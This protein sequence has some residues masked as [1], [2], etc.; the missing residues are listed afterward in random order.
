MAKRLRGAP[1]L[2]NSHKG[3]EGDDAQRRAAL[4]PAVRAPFEVNT[5]ARAHA[6]THII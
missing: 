4:E 5:H 2:V 3:W 1:V 6:R